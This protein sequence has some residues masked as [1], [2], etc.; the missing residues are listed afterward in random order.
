MSDY[1]G[2]M[3]VARYHTAGRTFRVQNTPVWQ[4]SSLQLGR[5]LGTALRSLARIHPSHLEFQR[6]KHRDDATHVWGG[7]SQLKVW[8]GYK[9]TKSKQSLGHDCAKRYSNILLRLGEIT[10]CVFFLP[11]LGLRFK[12]QLFLTVKAKYQVCIGGLHIIRYLIIII[13]NLSCF[14]MRRMWWTDAAACCLVRLFSSS[15]QSAE[16]HLQR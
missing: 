13:T 11:Q 12:M 10:N 6:E 4:L 14:N 15:S 1:C 2:V 16:S 7:F 5:L 3:T 8:K 9:E